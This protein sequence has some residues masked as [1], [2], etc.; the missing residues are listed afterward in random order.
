MGQAWRRNAAGGGMTSHLPHKDLG[1]IGSRDKRLSG[2]LSWDFALKGMQA[3]KSGFLQKLAT[4][5]GPNIQKYLGGVLGRSDAAEILS[6]AK[7]IKLNLSLPRLML[8]HR[9]LLPNRDNAGEVVVHRSLGSLE[10]RGLRLGAKLGPVMFSG[11]Q[12]NAGRDR[13]RERFGSIPSI[14]NT[15]GTKLHNATNAS[16]PNQSRLVPRVRKESWRTGN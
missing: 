6:S 15:H 13:Q 14:V 11:M 3:G 12:M 8:G 16:Q 1:L 7:H 4:I 10:G 5:T 2:L 9:S